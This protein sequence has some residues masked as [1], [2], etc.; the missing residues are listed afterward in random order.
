MVLPTAE[1]PPG[2]GWILSGIRSSNAANVGYDEAARARLVAM[3]QSRVTSSCSAG[4]R[5][6]PRFS[7]RTLLAGVLVC[8]LVLAA[9]GAQLRWRGTQQRGVPGRA[10]FGR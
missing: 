3:N 8:C 9:V 10:A 4:A 2:G 1:S 7:L 6:V 5:T